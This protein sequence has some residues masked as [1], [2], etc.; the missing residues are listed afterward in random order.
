MSHYIC[1]GS[2]GGESKN[3]GV[4]EAQFCTKESQALVSCDCKNDLHENAG[5]KPSEDDFAS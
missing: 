3:P 4:C 5:K 1:T 2:C